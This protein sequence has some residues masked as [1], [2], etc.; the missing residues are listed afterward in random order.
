MTQDEARSLDWLVFWI[1]AIW[2]ACVCGAPQ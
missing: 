1:A 2:T